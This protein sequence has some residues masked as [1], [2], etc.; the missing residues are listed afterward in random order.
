M[1]SPKRIASVNPIVR[2][3]YSLEN[4]NMHYLKG[5]KVYI[6]HTLMNKFIFHFQKMTL[7]SYT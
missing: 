5:A 3:V 2:C 1:I 4:K 6:C 7:H